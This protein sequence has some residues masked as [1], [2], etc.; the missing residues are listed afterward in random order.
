MKALTLLLVI[1]VLYSCYKPQNQDL[2]T[3]QSDFYKKD[4]YD[5]TRK[6]TDS[7]YISYGVIMHK[8]KW[9]QYVHG[10]EAFYFDTIIIKG[11]PVGI[12][13]TNPAPY[14]KIK[15]TCYIKYCLQYCE[16]TWHNQVIWPWGN[17]DTIFISEGSP[18]LPPTPNPPPY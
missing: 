2:I 5:S 12:P 4:G 9:M 18:C 8:I 16:K 11:T 14:F 10:G 13:V 3:P 7:T 6:I 1:G 17:V 15:D